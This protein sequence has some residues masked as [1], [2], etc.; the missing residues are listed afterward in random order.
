MHK[1]CKST[2]GMLQESKRSINN[3][4]LEQAEYTSMQ[5]IKE[6]FKVQQADRIKLLFVSDS[7]HVI[8]HKLFSNKCANERDPWG[9]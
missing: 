9:R 5:I 4:Q 2:A 7:G 1:P 8:F 3:F 6:I